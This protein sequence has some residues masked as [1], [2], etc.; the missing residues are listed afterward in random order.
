MSF[1]RFQTPVLHRIGTIVIHS[2]L[3][4][5]KGWLNQTRL[6]L[7]VIVSYT[8]YKCHIHC[9][10]DLWLKGCWRQF[11]A[12]IVTTA[13]WR[14]G[15][16]STDRCTDTTNKV[17]FSQ[18]VSHLLCTNVSHTLVY[19]DLYDRGI[20]DRFLSR[21]LN[22]EVDENGRIDIID[23]SSYVLTLDY[24]IK[25][26]NIHERY[27]CGVPVIIEGETGVGKTAVVE[28]LSK[29]WNQS[30]SLDWKRK[31]SRIIDFILEKL[32]IIESDVEAD[33]SGS[34]QVST[35]CIYL[36]LLLWPVVLVRIK[37][38]VLSSKVPL[39]WARTWAKSA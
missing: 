21:A 32:E 38:V 29:L 22:L 28:M 12:D 31:Q 1:D 3:L 11:W 18:F 30:L 17:C 27:E 15:T 6:F 14:K 34:Y 20:L 24:T 10:A 19:R 25:M 7:T 36:H 33:S 5:K 23:K 8:N 39:I 9:T 4:L 37:K 26:L 13:G 2:S 35:L 16:I